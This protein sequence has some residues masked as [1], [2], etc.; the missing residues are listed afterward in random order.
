MINDMK[1]RFTEETNLGIFMPNIL[2][3]Q[4]Q[5]NTVEIFESIC[6]QF[7]NIHGLNNKFANREAF[8]R[9]LQREMIWWKEYW[10]KEKNDIPDTAIKSLERCDKNMFPIIHSLLKVLASSTVSIASA[11]RIFLLLK[12]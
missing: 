12:E 11:E 7:L 5:E 6:N 8:I 3:S 9:K 2:I 4:I 1:S 10:N